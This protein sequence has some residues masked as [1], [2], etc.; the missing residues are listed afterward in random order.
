MPRLV[1]AR[2]E[3]VT[4]MRRRI[5]GYYLWMAICL[6]LLISSC[7][8]DVE[9]VIE[10]KQEELGATA[11]A[12]VKQEREST[13][14]SVKD[15][16][17]VSI[18][19]QAAQLTEKGRY[20]SPKEGSAFLLLD[21][22]LT[23]NGTEDVVVGSRHMRL[24]DSAGTVYPKTLYGGT[25]PEPDSA[26]PPGK[27]TSGEIA[28]EVPKAIEHLTWYVRGGDTGEEVAFDLDLQ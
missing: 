27:N 26:I 3:G 17:S 15:S 2:S 21:V 18:W 1:P 10:R 13:A 14:L 22:T 5:T 25:K 28:Y 9:T 4:T 24:S 23:N 8:S 6:A 12:R 16:G 19:L 7:T 11:T 20:V